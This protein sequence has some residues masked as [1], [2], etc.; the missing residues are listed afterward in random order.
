M[1]LA[2]GDVGVLRDRLLRFRWPVGIIRDF[3]GFGKIRD[4]RG[5]R[6]VWHWR[7]RAIRFIRDRGLERDVR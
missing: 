5:V 3:R 2:V 6:R 1:V 7:F 4:V